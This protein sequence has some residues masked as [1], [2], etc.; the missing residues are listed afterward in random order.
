MNFTSNSILTREVMRT[1]MMGRG[2]LIFMD[3]NVV[4]NDAI[5]LGRIVIPYVACSMIFNFDDDFIEYRNKFIEKASEYVE[6]YKN[7]QTRQELVQSLDYSGFLYR[8]SSGKNYSKDYVSWSQIDDLLY[9]YELEIENLKFFIAYV[10]PGSNALN[11]YGLLCF[12]RR[13]GVDF[14]KL[15]IEEDEECLHYAN[16]I[17]AFMDTEKEVLFPQLAKDIIYISSKNY[18]VDEYER[19]TKCINYIKKNINH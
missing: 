13:N 5:E 4:L 15:L 16:N 2:E 14:N 12:L 18:D 3:N 19:M 11:V 1:S 10:T 17:D 6:K 9:E 7:D 8:I